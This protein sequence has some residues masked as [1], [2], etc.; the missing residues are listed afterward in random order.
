MQV[1]TSLYG[2]SRLLGDGAGTFGL[3]VF[4]EAEEQRHI[5]ETN[6]PHFRGNIL[7]DPE[8]V[9]ESLAEAR[10]RGY[11]L[12]WG[13]RVAGAASVSVPITY[14]GEVVAAVS[15]AGV[16]DE[17]WKDTAER[18]ALRMKEEIARRA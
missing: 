17:R 10:V 13:F 2:E 7:R 4:L 6:L 18:L 15:L 3:L 5:L 12:G 11:S 9:K 16:Y 1:F 14:A 8:A